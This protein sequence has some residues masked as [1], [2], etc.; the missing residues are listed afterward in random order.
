[1]LLMSH[2]ASHMRVFLKLV[3]IKLWTLM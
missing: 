2:G 3:G 1:M